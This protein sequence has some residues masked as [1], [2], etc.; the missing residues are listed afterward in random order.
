MA[1]DI[2]LVRFSDDTD[3]IASQYRA[4]FP[5]LDQLA[6]SGEQLIYLETGKIVKHLASGWT[7]P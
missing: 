2:A 4:D 1:T 6:P 3:S 7:Q 5:I